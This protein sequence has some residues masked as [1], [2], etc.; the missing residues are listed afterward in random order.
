MGV[1]VPVHTEVNA[2]APTNR[3]ADWAEFTGERLPETVEERAD[4]SDSDSR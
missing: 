4:A 2:M 3:L 1:A